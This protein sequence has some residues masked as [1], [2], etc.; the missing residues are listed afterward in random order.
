MKSMAMHVLLLAASL[1]LQTQ[2]TEPTAVVKQ[3]RR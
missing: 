2:E 1:P 3:S